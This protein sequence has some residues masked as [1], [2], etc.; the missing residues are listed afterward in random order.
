M[1]KSTE[2]MGGRPGGGGFLKA[3]CLALAG[4]VVFAGWAGAQQETVALAAERGQAADDLLPSSS[5]TFY[6]DVLPILQD[7][8]VTCH[9]PQG[10]NLGGLVAPMS[11]LTYDEVR[12]WAPIIAETVR[13]GRMPPWGAAWEQR[14]LFKGE[15]YMEPEERAVLIAWA[16]AGAPAGNPETAPPPFDLAGLDDWAIGDPDLVTQFREPFLLEDDKWDYYVNLEIPL[17][18]EEHP[19]PRWIQASEFR[20]GGSHVHH[21]QSDYLGVI[22]PGRGAFEWPE[23]FGVLLPP[24]ATIP[25]RMHYYKQPG[26]GTAVEDVSGGAFKFYEDG[27]VIDHIV[28][29]YLF[30]Y[31]PTHGERIVVPAD[32]PDFTL[33]RELVFVED[34]YLISMH[35]HMHLRGK[36]Q[37]FEIKYPTGEG[38]WE[39]L[40]DV[41]DFDHAWQHLYQF[42]EPLLVPAGTAIRVTWVWDNTENNPRNILPVT[43][44]PFGIETYNE[45]ANARI[46]FSSAEKRNIVVGGPIPDDV[47]ES[48]GNWTVQGFN[49]I[50]PRPERA[51][52]IPVGP[53]LDHDERG[54]TGTD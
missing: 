16:E 53:G 24:E 5:A 25:M 17:A 36:S 21:I 18:L 2:G 46:F 32:V 42:K 30:S 50:L 19:E 11:L 23:G 40:L 10:P 54:R 44:V 9:R 14:G 22:V 12:P 38:K 52:V 27:A 34:T 28:Q 51:P 35:A 37:L 47:L 6:G 41:P 26:P 49:P 29:T 48:A 15:R 13:E 45:M 39:V 33:S 43:D 1:S 20:P 31:G 7:N 4:L 8:C 3:G